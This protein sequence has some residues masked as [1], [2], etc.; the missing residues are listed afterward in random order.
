MRWCGIVFATLMLT[1]CALAERQPTGLVNLAAAVER[2]RPAVVQIVLAAEGLPQEV[3][4]RVGRSFLLGAIGTG[5]LVNEDGYVITA[6]HVMETGERLIRESATVPAARKRLLVGLVQQV[7][8]FS[9]PHFMQLE[10]DL[11]DTDP[12]HDL[13]L[14]KL[15]LN[16]F[17]GEVRGPIIAGKPTAI[18]VNTVMLR[19][20][21]PKD[22]EPIGL[23]GY[24]L[25]NPVLITKGGWLATA[26]SL[27]VRAP[28]QAS[29]S[30]T[31]QAADVADS[32]LA[33]IEVNNGNSGGPV[34]L[35]ATA[36]VIGVASSFVRAAIKNDA[37]QTVNLDGHAL[38]YS[39]GL[40]VVVPTHYVITLLRKNGV[41]WHGEQ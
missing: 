12:R 33:D 2:V 35:A 25:A 15:R 18:V 7:T 10:F 32:Y 11:I 41:R 39:S 17:R 24:P 22:G 23:S 6:N 31:L 36:E 1:G 27:D 16:P 3:E 30:G 37:D 38:T 5:F 28:Q 8:A 34:Y 9:H 13:A 19:T 29:N 4:K 40:A 26:W 14:L 20:A 21:R